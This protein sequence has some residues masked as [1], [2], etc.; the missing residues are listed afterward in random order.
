MKCF[1]Q[2]WISLYSV[3]MWHHVIS[4]STWDSTSSTSAYTNIELLFNH[5][6]QRRIRGDIATWIICRLAAMG[7]YVGLSINTYLERMNE[8]KPWELKEGI[9]EWTTLQSWYGQTLSFEIFFK[10]ISTRILLRFC[11]Y[12][13]VVK[14]VRI[15]VAVNKVRIRIVDIFR[16]HVKVKI[17]RIRVVVKIFRIRVVVKIFHIRVVVKLFR[18][19]VAVK[20]VRIHVGVKIV[21][22]R[23]VSIFRIRVAVKI[24]R[25][26]V[27]VMIVRI[28]VVRI[29]R[30][31]V[32]VK[33]VRIR[34]VVRIFRIRVAVKIF[35]I[36]V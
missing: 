6:Y 25:I 21:R 12:R 18:I 9:K 11:C 8:S 20:I 36:R 4:T 35:D 22:I 29:F 30:I 16:T 1:F 14:N 27:A 28:R 32:A 5:A 34:V 26:R 13:F 3:N 17:F 19:R 15:W 24:F 7:R 2:R 10:K 23:V 31:R 33:I